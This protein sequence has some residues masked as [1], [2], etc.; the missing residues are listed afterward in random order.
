MNYATTTMKKIIF[1]IL[2]LT[3]IIT[4]CKKRFEDGPLISFRSVKS[5]IEGTWKVDKFYINDVDSTYDFN[6]K[7]G[8]EI[9]FSNK[10]SKYNSVCYEIYLKN[11]N[12]NKVLLGSWEWCEDDCFSTAFFKDT[13]FLNN[14]GAFGS[15]R[16]ESCWEILKLTNKEF[17]L[18][19]SHGGGWGTLPSG[20]RYAINL[21]KQ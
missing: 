9:E 4:A 13:S 21:K 3:V 8:C 5:R 16:E 1:I 12:N 7:L 15:E 6:K 2:I 11:C 20:T 18:Y 14:L 10:V 19:E 17:N